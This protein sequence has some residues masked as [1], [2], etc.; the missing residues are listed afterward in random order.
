MQ[1]IIAKKSVAF[2]VL[3]ASTV[4]AWMQTNSKQPHSFLQEHFDFSNQ[5]LAAIDRG[6]IVTKLPKTSDNREVA[7]LGV[8]RLNVSK[9]FFVE[10]F[11]DIESFKKSEMVLQVRK[12]SSPPRLEDMTELNLEREHLNALKECKVG[13]C[14]VK[15]PTQWIERFLKVKWSAPDHKERATVLTRQFLL[16]YVRSYLKEGNAALIEYSDQPYAQRLADEVRSFL[17]QSPYLVQT[18]PGFKEYLAEFPRMQMPGTDNFIYWSKEKVG[19]LKPVLSFT[20]VAIHRGVSQ[21]LTQTII[22]SKQI[23]ANHYF[24]GSLALTWVVDAETDSEK[25]GC[26]LIYLNRSRMDALRGGLNWLKR[27]IARGQIREG[28]LK[29]LQL[30]RDRI[31]RLAERP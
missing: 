17:D 1:H 12:L 6:K 23:Y 31:E 22:A 3:L 5:D 21:S 11:I 8:A 28:M 16:D 18:A 27:Y 15:V 13:A 10:K 26:Y 29:N 14:K 30:I 7:V 9:E 2:L 4:P 19:A 24:E 25:T 20:H